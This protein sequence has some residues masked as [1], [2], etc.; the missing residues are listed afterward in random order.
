MASLILGYSWHNF[1]FFLQTKL[2]KMV[3]TIKTGKILN[4]Y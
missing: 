2:N 3:Y 1:R 4:F